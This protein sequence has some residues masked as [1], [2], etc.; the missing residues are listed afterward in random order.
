MHCNAK[1][2]RV[3]SFQIRETRTY[4]RGFG[5]VGTI[6]HM[7][8]GLGFPLSKSNSLAPLQN[9]MGLSKLD[10]E[11]LTKTAKG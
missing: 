11:S 3:L 1:L 9:M 4:A 7:M 10:R 5:L 6:P 8:T 2:V